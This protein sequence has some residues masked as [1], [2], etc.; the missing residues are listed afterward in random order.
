LQQYRAI[1]RQNLQ[2]AQYLVSLVQQ[3]REL[4]LMAPVPMNIVCYRYDPGNTSTAELNRINKEILM[5]LHE[6]GIAAPTYTA[7]NGAYV[8]RAAITNHRSQLHDFDILVTETL[9]IG[10]ELT[11]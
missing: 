8:I 9:R 3:E 6:E 1:I 11:G 2:Q 10:R 7:L 5:R 4:E